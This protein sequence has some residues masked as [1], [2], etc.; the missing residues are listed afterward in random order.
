MAG[1]VTP[2]PVGSCFTN[3]RGRDIEELTNGDS[4]RARKGAKYPN[5]TNG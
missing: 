4:D 5:K 1:N 3:G 2:V